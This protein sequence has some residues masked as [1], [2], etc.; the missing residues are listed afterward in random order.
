[1]IK[2]AV[3]LNDARVVTE[4]TALL[5]ITD[6]ECFVVWTRDEDGVCE[7]IQF[8]ADEQARRV[9]R[10]CCQQS[11]GGTWLSRLLARMGW[12]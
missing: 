3:N 7:I 10:A 11:L 9:G 2:F 6:A 4:E 8:G 1:M 12:L 5:N